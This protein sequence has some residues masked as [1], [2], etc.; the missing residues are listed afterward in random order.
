MP[1]KMLVA[2]CI[3]T[4]VLNAASVSMIVWMTSWPIVVVK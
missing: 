4:A 2:A 1:L 3:V